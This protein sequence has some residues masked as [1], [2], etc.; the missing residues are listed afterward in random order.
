MPRHG[1]PTS[2]ALILACAGTLAATPA[3]AQQSPPTASQP[4]KTKVVRRPIVDLKKQAEQPRPGQIMPGQPQPKPPEPSP[5]PA[6]PAQAPEQQPVPSPPAAPAPEPTP[7]PPAAEP[8]PVPI[9][10]E[11]VPAPAQPEPVPPPPPPQPAPVKQPSS[12]PADRGD[13]PVGLPDSTE[14]APTRTPA[15]RV[16]KPL[17]PA[18]IPVAADR[19]PAAE[20][21]PVPQPSPSPEP[22]AQPEPV[23]PAAAEEPAQPALPSYITEV[24]P[25]AAASPAEAPTPQ[26][27]PAAEPVPVVLEMPA[28]SPGESPAQ[29][30]PAPTVT[31]TGEP[32]RAQVILVEG[33]KDVIQWR[34]DGG[35]WKNLVASDR[36]DGR[37]EVRT[38]LGAAA[39]F[40]LADQ[41]SVRVARLSRVEFE[42]RPPAAAGMPVELVVRLTRGEV[43]VK[44]LPTMPGGPAPAT[45]R[46][47]TPDREFT[48]RLATGVRFDAFSGTRLKV[49]GGEK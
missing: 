24:N 23:A 25:A 16:T 26:P 15:A 14:P 38:G 21:A 9:P 39:T 47:I 13:E 30:L 19:K 11:Q 28:E 36:V 7:P 32:I 8:A 48:T 1:C 41:V 42:T 40:T 34:I 44:P 49:V 2:I 33:P 17:K 3:W 37:I 31:P 6:Q 35:E 4:G 12:P 29:A 45:I 18:P 10:I 43:D 5:A 22:A 20:P 27:E 46:I